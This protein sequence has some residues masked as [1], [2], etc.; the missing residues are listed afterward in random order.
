MVNTDKKTTLKIRKGGSTLITGDFTIEH[1][2]G[3]I[4]HKTKCALC[5]CGLSTNMPF[6]DGKHKEALFEQD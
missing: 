4:E 6:C 3:T 2:D 1:M 5:R